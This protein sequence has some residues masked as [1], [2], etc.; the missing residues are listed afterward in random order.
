[1]GESPDR[2]K[3]RAFPEIGAGG[4]TKLDGTVEFYARVQALLRPEMR[5]LDFG[6]GRAEWFEDDLCTFRRK[7]RH[8]RGKVREVVACDID[9]AV[10]ENRAAVRWVHTDP[11]CP[12]PFED[13]SFGLIIA[14]YVFEHLAQPAEIA[15]ELT[16]VLAPGGWLCART[17]SGLGY[18][19]MASQLVRNTRYA[20]LLRRVQPGRKAIDVFPT[21][22]RLN[23][24]SAVRRYFPPAVFE[25]FSCRHDPEPAYYFGNRALFTAL[26]F[27]HWMLPLAFSSQLYMFLRRNAP[28]I[29][30]SR[31]PNR[32][33]N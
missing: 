3:A 9:E 4:Y 20:S 23:T 29:D 33:R 12:V 18:I 13:G 28:R 6:A 30:S 16:R 14:D 2:V 21:V 26:R 5:V 11:A 22:D 8:I 32:R 31:E 10:R 25:S 15:R 27:V 24:L 19:A 17:P 7:L 1:M